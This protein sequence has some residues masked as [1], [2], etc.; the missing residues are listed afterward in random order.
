MSNGYDLPRSQLSTIDTDTP[1]VSVGD[2]R[3]YRVEGLLL[4]SDEERDLLATVIK[5]ERIVRQHGAEAAA[6]KQWYETVFGRAA[7]LAALLAAVADLAATI[8]AIVS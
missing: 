4:F 1:C 8:H 3:K 7:I 2:K 5:R 6:R